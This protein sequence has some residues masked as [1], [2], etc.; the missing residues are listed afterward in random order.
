[1]P[2]SSTELGGANSVE[3]SPETE[4]DK[5]AMALIFGLGSAA[6]AGSVILGGIER[7]FS[8]HREYLVSAMSLA[9]AALSR[10]FYLDWRRLKKS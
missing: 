9:S 5:F 3:S 1:M 2:D 10:K 6:M 7:G 4:D 8:D